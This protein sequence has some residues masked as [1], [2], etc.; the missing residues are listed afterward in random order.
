MGRYVGKFSKRLG[1]RLKAIRGERTVRE[2]A[3]LTGVSKSAWN[4]LEQGQHNA[5]LATIERMCRGLKCQPGQLLDE[6]AKG[7]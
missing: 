7:R 2:M 5:T 4:L 3:R 6:K 1:R